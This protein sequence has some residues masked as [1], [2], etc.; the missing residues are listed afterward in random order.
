[1]R[2]SSHNEMA[3]I[4]RDLF[5]A[6]IISRADDCSASNSDHRSHPAETI[7]PRT[8]KDGHLPDNTHSAYSELSFPTDNQ[9]D[10]ELKNFLIERETIRDRVFQNLSLETYM[11]NFDEL[12]L[13]GL[14]EFFLESLKWFIRLELS[15]NPLPFF[16]SNFYQKFKNHKVV[17]DIV[18]A[19]ERGD[20]RFW[21]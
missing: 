20:S 3:T 6:E 2:Q 9:P 8:E 19:F 18:D 5:G 17:I 21:Q 12:K 7:I 11:E 14:D 1:M 4:I 13:Y 16:E 15:E 10:E